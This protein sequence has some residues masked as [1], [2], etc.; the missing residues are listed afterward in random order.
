V[1]DRKEFDIELV[2]NDINMSDLAADIGI[3]P[4]TM[5]R[6]VA[7]GGDFTR[8]EIEKITERLHLD[9]PMKIFFARKL[10]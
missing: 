8:E 10:T 7:D 9:S 2:R 3:H 5:Y 4:S 1:F 6:K